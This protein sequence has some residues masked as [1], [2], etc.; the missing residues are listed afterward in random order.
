VTN[1]SDAALGLWLQNYS[2]RKGTRKVASLRV[3]FYRT[4]P[5]HS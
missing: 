5:F 1:S 2:Y 3:P 4:L